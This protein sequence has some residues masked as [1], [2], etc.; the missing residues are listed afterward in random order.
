[1]PEYQFKETKLTC[2]K[3]EKGKVRLVISKKEG[4]EYKFFRCS[5]YDCDWNG[6][7]YNQDNNK[8]DIID[9]CP[10]C[11]GI[12]YV[13]NGKN[14]PF[15]G[16]SH[17]PDCKQTRELTEEEARLLERLKEKNLDEFIGDDK[18]SSQEK[19]AA[20]GDSSKG[21]YAAQGDISQKKDHAT[22]DSSS[23]E[24]A[25]SN[26]EEPV[27]ER[28]KT[29]LKCPECE[30]GDVILI[31]K[32]TGDK[33]TKFFRC[34]EDDCNWNGGFYNRDEIKTDV[35][36][37]CPSC[38][39]ILYEKIG[40]KGPFMAC[41]N[42][43]KCKYTRNIEK[44]IDDAESE[45]REDIEAPEN[46]PLEEDISAPEDIETQEDTSITNEDMETPQE[47]HSRQDVETQENIQESIEETEEEESME[48]EKPKAEYER[49]ETK[50][51][52]PECME[53]QVI[54]IRNMDTGK[55]FFRCTNN[56]CDW[57]GGPY[58]QPLKQLK[59]VTYCQEP[60]CKGI[61]YHT[62]GKYGPYK[63]CTWFSKTGCRPKKKR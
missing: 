33:E 19:D 42:F 58:S 43:P 48:E 63:A 22:G 44:R 62:E 27:Y 54:L 16:C 39:G 15:L 47:N 18:D 12:L 60:G 45:I 55:G 3:C 17:F 23:Q 13:R 6:G 29:D 21:K 31:I 20:Q 5:E 24:N 61:N 46:E 50:L 32:T 59:H 4:K 10:S 2:P 52:C 51:L 41:S 1:M 56:D 53:G 7:F 28:I 35:L 30:K 11:D 49:F 34:S 26:K 57:D 36:E 14:G 8:I 38:N 40:R 37:H 9:N 25:D